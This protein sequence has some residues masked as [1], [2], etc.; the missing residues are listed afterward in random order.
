MNPIVMG[1]LLFITIAGLDAL[2]AFA[3]VRFNVEL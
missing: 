3:L 1:A 2:V